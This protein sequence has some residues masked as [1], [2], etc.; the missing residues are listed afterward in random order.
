MRSRH[1]LS[2]CGVHIRAHAGLMGAQIPSVPLHVAVCTQLSFCDFSPKPAG[3]PLGWPVACLQTARSAHRSSL[4]LE[5]YA[6]PYFS[7]VHRNCLSPLSWRTSR[8]NFLPFPFWHINY[9]FPKATVS[10]PHSEMLQKKLNAF[11]FISN[12]K[13]ETERLPS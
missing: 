12:L 5:L 13:L 10:K 3:S 6:L 11:R 4:Q 8:L 1:L 7:L 2:H 9:P